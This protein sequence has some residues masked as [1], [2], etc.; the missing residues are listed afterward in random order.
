MLLPCLRSIK[1]LSVLFFF[2][3]FVNDDDNKHNNNKDD[4]NNHTR[5]LLITSIYTLF[6]RTGLVK[7][8]GNTRK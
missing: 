2:I 3:F 8:G 7:E 4:D 5:F 1:T 6:K